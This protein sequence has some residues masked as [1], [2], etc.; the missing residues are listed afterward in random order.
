MTSLLASQ[1]FYPLWV[2]CVGVLPFSPP[3]S[4]DPLSHPHRAHY[5]ATLFLDYNVIYTLVQIALSPSLPSTSI[6]LATRAIV[7][8]PTLRTSTAW[9]VAVGIYS[10]CTFFWVVIIG[11]WLDLYLAFIKPWGTGGRVPIGRVYRGASWVSAFLFATTSRVLTFSFSQIF[12][13]LLHVLV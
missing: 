10:A 4:A 8:I 3:F 6:R 11:L 12:Q 7:D 5:P 9:W 13:P 1:M 2:L